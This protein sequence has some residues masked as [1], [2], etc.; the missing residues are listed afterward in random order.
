MFHTFMDNVPVVID[1][2]TFVPAPATA[3]SRAF[4]WVSPICRPKRL[5]HPRVLQRHTPADWKLS[6]DHMKA[7]VSPVRVEPD[8]EMLGAKS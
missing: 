3:S 2:S 5:A 6:L 1:P 4:F 8:S 7:V